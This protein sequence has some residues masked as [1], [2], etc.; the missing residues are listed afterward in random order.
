MFSGLYFIFSTYYSI[1]AKNAAPKSLVKVCG[2][3][4][5]DPELPVPEGKSQGE[6][7]PSLSESVIYLTVNV[8]ESVIAVT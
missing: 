5:G 6:S 8:S 4:L 3:L 7:S 2:A 1:K